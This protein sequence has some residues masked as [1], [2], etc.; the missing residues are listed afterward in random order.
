MLDL[1][2]NYVEQVKQKFR[3]TWFEDKYKYY[4]CA[5]FCED[6]TPEESTWVRHQF[7]SVKDG[8]VIGYIGYQIDR[9]AGDLVYGLNIINFESV[10]S[11]TF[12]I[13]LGH[14]LKNIF[15]K[16][17]LR[18]LSFSV[19]VGNPIESSYD[20]MCERYGGRIVGVQKDHVRLIDNKFY[21][22]K[23]YEILSEDYWK[24][25]TTTED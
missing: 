25:K 13:D 12:S 3:S 22:E 5:N 4:H 23:L 9:S 20:N 17:G 2:I 14:T 1:A 24:S 21:D 16:F 6:W 19:V 10:P 7:V 18:K 11:M 15:E 8:E